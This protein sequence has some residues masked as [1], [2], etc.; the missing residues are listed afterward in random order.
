MSLI[1]DEWPCRDIK[2]DGR[3]YF[4]HAI[5]YPTQL[6]ANDMLQYRAP[7]L[8]FDHD[9]NFSWEHMRNVLRDMERRNGRPFDIFWDGEKWVEEFA[10]FEDESPPPIF[11]SMAQPTHCP[12]P[13]VQAVIKREGHRDGT[14]DTE[15]MEVGRG[16]P[17]DLK[18]LPQALMRVHCEDCDLIVSVKT[19]GNGNLHARH[20]CSWSKLGPFGVYDTGWVNVREEE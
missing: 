11:Q 10:V 1:P 4:F 3:V 2:F 16:L 7:V 5:A 9:D 20:D 15:W 18:H 8:M 19:D 13:L 6:G 14:V 12:V 17:D